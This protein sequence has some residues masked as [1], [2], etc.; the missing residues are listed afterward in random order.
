MLPMELMSRR[1]LFRAPQASDARHIFDSYTRKPEVSRYMIWQPHT[2]VSQSEEFIA[3]CIA[4]FGEGA[5]RPYI[6][7]LREAPDAP[8]GMLEGRVSGHTVDIGY[9][10]APSHWGRGLM[11][12]AIEALAAAALAMPALFRV[13]ATCDVDNANSARALE[14]AGFKREGRLERFMVHPNIGPEPRPSYMYARCR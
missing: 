1:L 3:Q 5:R 9:V 8:I 14:K 2:R 6:L 10:L 12:E 13:Q 11:P 4:W 7:S